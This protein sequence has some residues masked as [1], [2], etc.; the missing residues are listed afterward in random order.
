MVSCYP[1]AA[2]Y[3]EKLSKQSTNYYPYF[4][5]IHSIAASA[6]TIPINSLLVLLP[7]L[8]MPNAPRSVTSLLPGMATSDGAGVRLTR[9]IGSPELD[10]LDPFLMLDFFESDDPDDYIAGFPSHPHRGFETVTYMLA[11]RVRHQDSVGH[12]GVIETGG[13]Q[14]MTAGRGIIH[15]EMPEQESGR[16][17]G[18]QLW[19]NLPASQK[20][21]SP[22]YQEFPAHQVPQEVRANEATIRVITGQTSLGVT[23]PVHDI[24][25][26]PLY[27]DVTVNKRS[28]FEEPIPE[29]HNGFIFVIDGTLLIESHHSNS[30]QSVT[31]RQ[32]AVLGEGDRLVAHTSDVPARFL[33]VAGRPIGEPV[34]RYGPLSLI[35]I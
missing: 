30:A 5:S 13:I 20:M 9:Y 4:F 11:G 24:V 33:L 8:T 14:W 6:I 18:F 12:A 35:H 25:T 26:D 22:A 19:V 34:A 15:S 10:S 21:V 3:C 31:R 29:T 17:A 27:L 32:L 2:H 16:L 28:T 1:Q 7:L 23:G